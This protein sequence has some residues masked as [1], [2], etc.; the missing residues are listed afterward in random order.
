M[1]L[2]EN[3]GSIQLSKENGTGFLVGQYNGSSYYITNPRNNSKY[4]KLVE[5][6]DANKTFPGWLAVAADIKDNRGVIIQKYPFP[7]ATASKPLSGYRA[8]GFD[9]ITGVITGAYDYQ[10]TFLS[11]AEI[12]SLGDSSSARFAPGIR[13][14][15]TND[16]SAIFAEIDN[17]LGIFSDVINP[18]TGAATANGTSPKHFITAPSAFGKK[19]ADI[20]TNYKFKSDGPI[21]IDLDSFG[22]ASPKL[23]I[24][25]KS[26]KAAKLAKKDID[27]IYD[28]QT[29]YLSYNENG[30]LPGFGEGGVISILKGGPKLGIQNFE[31]A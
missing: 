10:G 18:S 26:K 21:A 1:A 25:R 28:Q 16:E 2:I 7:Q 31:F 29:G 5:G 14:V 15:Y 13:L 27:F 23:K 9:P 22:D 12:D 20:I 6:E 24:A 11:N 17:W 4:P 30:R 19:N 8:Y 3:K